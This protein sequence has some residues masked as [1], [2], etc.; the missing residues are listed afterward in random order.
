MEMSNQEKQVVRAIQVYKS[1]A[2]VVRSF[3][4]DIHG[5]I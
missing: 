4:S 3:L 1:A 5:G 2:E